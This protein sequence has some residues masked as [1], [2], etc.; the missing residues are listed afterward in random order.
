VGQVCREPGDKPHLFKVLGSPLVSPVIPR[1]RVGHWFGR[2]KLDVDVIRNLMHLV[3]V[4][5]RTPGGTV[6]LV[7][8]LPVAHQM[9]QDVLERYTCKRD[10]VVCIP[11][12]FVKLPDVFLHL[13]CPVVNY[14]L[15]LLIMLV[16]L[17]AS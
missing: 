12:Q 4:S 8:H 11:R 5:I 2:V 9:V 17:A 16:E 13:S 7:L 6:G 14:S 3:E 10:L 1:V 15:E